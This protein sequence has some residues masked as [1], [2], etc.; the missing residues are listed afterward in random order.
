MPSLPAGSEWPCPSM[1]VGWAA[2]RASSIVT[3]ISAR[4]LAARWSPLRR[5]PSRRC[6]LPTT[7]EPIAR[8]SWR[9]R[10][11]AILAGAVTSTVSTDAGAA[12]GAT[13]FVPRWR[14]WAACRVMLR[15]SA[16]VLHEAP[17]TRAHATA[18]RSSR[19]SSRRKVVIARSASSGSSVPTARRRRPPSW[20]SPWD[21]LLAVY[22]SAVRST[23]AALRPRGRRTVSGEAQAA[24]L[25]RRTPVHDDL[26]ARGAGAFGRPLVDDAELHPDRP[27][28]D[29]DRLV[30]VG[31][32]GVR[33]AEDVD[34][35]HA[36]AVRQ[37][38]QPGFAALTEDLLAGG[39][40]VH[41]D[42]TVPAPLEQSR[43]ALAVPMGAGRAADDGPRAAGGQ[44]VADRGVERGG[45]AAGDRPRSAAV[46]APARCCRPPVG[47]RRHVAARGLLPRP[48]LP[49]GGA[50][51][52]EG[53]ARLAE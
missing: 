6:S 9:P 37:R 45:D 13:C 39:V 12:S 26:E 36:R 49:G 33:A 7:S 25:D 5:I 17:A 41:R 24:D 44:E 51:L 53:G 48:A 11:T 23:P 35:V 22:P 15:A 50:A 47:G 20:R 4:T 18:S 19:S 28:A 8:A 27:R 42:D 46:V 30:D 31:A 2:I 29:G 43:D 40:G 16:I 32:G 38:G 52:V 14:F 3:P 21:T 34:D 1:S 10:R